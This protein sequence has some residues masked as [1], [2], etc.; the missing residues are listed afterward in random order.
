[1]A[2][3]QPQKLPWMTLLTYA[4]TAALLVCAAFWSSAPAAKTVSYSDFVTA[5]RRT[6]LCRFVSPHPH[7]SAD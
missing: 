4:A 5:I 3:Q 7:L 6:V 2:E 1:M